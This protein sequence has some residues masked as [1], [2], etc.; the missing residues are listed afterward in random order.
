MQ[1]SF[2]FCLEAFSKVSKFDSLIKLTI[3]RGPLLVLS[4]HHWRRDKGKLV[5]CFHLWLSR[6]LTGDGNFG[7][8]GKFFPTEKMPYIFF[9]WLG[10]YPSN[11]NVCSLPEFMTALQNLMLNFFTSSSDNYLT[12]T[13]LRLSSGDI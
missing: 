2:S 7:K 6:D 8:E 1:F 3:T 5:S 12:Y 4:M 11:L 13:T 10:P 9:F